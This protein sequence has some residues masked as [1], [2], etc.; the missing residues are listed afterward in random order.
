[1][2]SLKWLAAA[3]VIALAVGACQATATP[4]PAGGGTTR[5]VKIEVVT[6]GQATDPF[7]SVVKN[8]VDAAAQDMGVS[9]NYSAP[10]TFDMPAMAQL[11]DA[12]IAKNPDGLVVSFPDESALGPKIKAAVDAGIPVLTINSGSDVYAKYGAM[13]HIGQTEYEAGLGAGKRM[14][15]A[16][17]TK[18]ICVNQEVGNAALD[19]RCNGFKDGIGADKFKVVIAVDLADP[20]GAQQAVAAALQSDPSIDGVLTLGPTGSA[21]A[22]KALEAGGLMGKVKIATFDLSPDVLKAIDKGDMLFAIDQQQFL[23]GYLPIVFL[24]LYKEFGLM[25]GGGGVILT[26]PGFVTQANAKQ[27]ID[28]SAK[29][30]R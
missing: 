25:P 13:A 27:V 23:Q 7:W 17:V 3:A 10:G 11:I 1:M 30:I 14:A 20:T 18:A 8:G 22:L 19:L 4:T 6:H 2:R 26:G 21:P 28:L 16:G 12:A 29:G 15:D 24:T 5:N 9:V